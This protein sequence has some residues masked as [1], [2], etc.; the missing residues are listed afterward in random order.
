MDTYG[1]LSVLPPVL[2]IVLAIKT[3][4]VFISLFF[5]IWLGW[6]ILSRGNPLAGMIGALDSCVN[7]FKDPD[8]TKVIMFSALVGAYRVYPVFGGYGRLCELDCREGI[9]S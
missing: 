7:V 6:V 2:A 4:Q 9:G 1:W 8:N 3:K 5:G